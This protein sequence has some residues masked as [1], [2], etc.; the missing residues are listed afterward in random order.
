MPLAVDHLYGGERDGI[1]LSELKPGYKPSRRREESPL[2]ARLTLHAASVTFLHPESGETI[3]IEA[4][5]PKDLRLVLRDLR[6]Y[7]ALTAPPES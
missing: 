7:Q 1:R 6:R 3:T 4:P 5:L 2:I